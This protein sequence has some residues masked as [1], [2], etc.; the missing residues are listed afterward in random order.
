MKWTL[1]HDVNVRDVFFRAI[2]A[3]VF[4]PDEMKE[5][6]A[7]ERLDRYVRGRRQGDRNMAAGLKSMHSI[8]LAESSG[9]S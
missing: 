7:Y 9:S 4:A 3:T 6:D 2:T 1:D 5:S 8:Y